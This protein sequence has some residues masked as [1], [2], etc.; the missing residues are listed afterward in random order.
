MTAAALAGPG[1]LSW[2]TWRQHRTGLVAVLGL[3]GLTAA[4]MA[5]TELNPGWHADAISTSGPFSLVYPLTVLDVLLLPAVAGLVLGAPLLAHEAE[6]GTVRFAW[7]QDTGKVTLLIGKVL[8]VAAGLAVAGAGLG[9]EFDWWAE[10]V[11]KN[12]NYLWLGRQFSFHPLPYAGW[13]VFAF[14]L[15]VALGAFV[16]RTVP[17]LVG[18]LIGYVAVFYLDNWHLRMFYLP[19]LR[20]VVSWNSVDFGFRQDHVGNYVID[21]GIVGPGGKLISYYTPGKLFGWT[22][23]AAKHAAQWTTYQP[24]SRFVLFQV[25]ELGYLT[26]LSAA[27]VTAAVLVIRRR[28]V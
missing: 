19:P 13:T 23:F 1:R 7:T 24:A 26:L 12:L 9:L 15:G 2:V 28:S 11:L 17:A 21:S 18:T 20:S 4:F 5:A 22:N 25:L 10:P 16:R 6:S 27:L 8:S 14:C 3:F